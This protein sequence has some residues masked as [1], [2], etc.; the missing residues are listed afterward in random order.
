VAAQWARWCQSPDYFIVDHPDAAERLARFDR[1]LRAY[2]FTDDEYAPEG[3]VENL[4]RRLESARL[5]HRCIRPPEVGMA[6]IGH[7][8]FFRRG[9]RDTLWTGAKAFLDDVLAGR[10][11]AFRERSRSPGRDGSIGV[12]AA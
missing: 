6:A 3:A 10:E 9:L 4:L 5:E 8:G 12:Q 1:P 11:L 7:F 2:T